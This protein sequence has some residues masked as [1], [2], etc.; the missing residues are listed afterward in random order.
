MLPETRRLHTGMADGINEFNQQTI[1]EF[2][3]NEGKVGGPFESVQLLLLHT[4]GAKSGKARIAPLVFRQEGDALAVFGSKAG[5]D[6]NPD[7]YHNVLANPAVSVEVG[8]DRFDAV[9][10]VAEGAE[11]DRIWE[12]QKT[13]VPN[14]AEYEKQT[15]RIIPVVVLERSA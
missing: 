10:R 15:D 8:T 4:T 3:A 11:R 2:R 13:E 6:D 9:A 7:W 1:D 5:A 14:F 12:R